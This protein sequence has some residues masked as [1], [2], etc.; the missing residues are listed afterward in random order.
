MDALFQSFLSFLGLPASW[1]VR[2]CYFQGWIHGV[3]R[4]SREVDL[5][6]FTNYY[7]CSSWAQNKI[8]YK[9]W[10]CDFWNLQDS[11][12]FANA[13]P[14][15]PKNIWRT[16]PIIAGVGFLALIWK[17]SGNW[18]ARKSQIEIVSLSGFHQ[19]NLRHTHLVPTCSKQILQETSSGLSTSKRRKA[20]GSAV[21]TDILEEFRQSNASIYA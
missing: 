8:S 20:A 10:E 1:Q 3:H 4:K 21:W 11:I 7:Y 15:T 9:P 16:P 5:L 18:E 19:A 6:W 14:V 17:R 13:N 12:V 2:T